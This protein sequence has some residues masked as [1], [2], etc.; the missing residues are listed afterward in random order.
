[1]ITY[2]FGG[3][4]SC[5]DAYFYSLFCHF[6]VFRLQKL[7]HVAV[8]T[9]P[10]HSCKVRDYY[11]LI[12]QVADSCFLGHLTGLPLPSRNTPSAFLFRLCR[13]LKQYLLH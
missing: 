10:A 12:I 5:D 1:M 6:K 13:K 8:E 9:V 11:N 2:K 7:V 3:V 4:I